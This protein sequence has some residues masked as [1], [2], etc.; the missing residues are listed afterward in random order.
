[1]EK[2]R[3][4]GSSDH[5]ACKMELQ[6]KISQVHTI[7]IC[8]CV[9]ANI[10]KHAT[11]DVSA[12]SCSGLWQAAQ[13]CVLVEHRVIPADHPCEKHVF[14]TFA[15]IYCTLSSWNELEMGLPTLWGFQALLR[16]SRV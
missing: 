4:D 1:M 15:S 5:R 11:Q 13:V 14:H 8:T 10:V 9:A 3:P 6:M 12:T 2:S 16:E 7:L